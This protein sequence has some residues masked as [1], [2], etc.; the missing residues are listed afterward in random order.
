MVKRSFFR[1][2]SGVRY[3]QRRDRKRRVLIAELLE[4]RRLLTAGELLNSFDYLPAAITDSYQL[5]TGQPLTVA[6]PGLLENDTHVANDLASIALISRPQFGSLEFGSAGGFIYQPLGEYQGSDSFRYQ[7]ENSHGQSS[8]VTVHLDVVESAQ[9]ALD[10]A[11]KPNVIVVDSL[12]DNLVSDFYTTLREAI[13]IANSNLSENDL[14]IFSTPSGAITINPSLGPLTISSN[15]HIRSDKEHQ[16]LATNGDTRIFQIESGSEVVLENLTV[17]EG[18]IVSGNG[19]G[20]WNAG[21]L[22]LRNVYL[23]DN[24]ASA[25]NGGAIYNASGA[26][27]QI[28][29]STIANSHAGLSG[30]GIYNDS[31][32]FLSVLSSTLSGNT[33]DVSGGAVQNN[34]A[35]QIYSS[36]IALGDSPSGANIKTSSPLSLGNTIVAQGLSDQDIDGQIDSHGGNLIGNRQV[37][38]DLPLFP[39][40]SFYI[41]A[42]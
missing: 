21:D 6:A 30:G 18:H 28:V 29:D 41:S 10:I 40:I 12:G 20:I 19:A 5:N 9:D 1:G 13:E 22:T 39:H 23:A 17:A 11:D 37:T 33:A 34:G 24:S 27:L 26:S 35:G 7:V 32:A 3:N 38:T 14:I 8:P 36:T 25:G 15:I 4:N 42:N 16:W 2:V 31:N